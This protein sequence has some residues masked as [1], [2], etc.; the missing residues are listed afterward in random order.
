MD[1]L[2]RHWEKILLTAA[3]L[4]LLT[5]G[6]ILLLK[7]GALSRGLEHDLIPRAGKGAPIPP[8]DSSPYDLAYQRLTQPVLWTNSASDPFQ[9]AAV[10]PPDPDETNRPAAL[11]DCAITLLRVRQEPFTMIF[12][13]YIGDGR[14]FQINM[15]FRPYSFFVE[16]AGDPIR[17]QFNQTGYVVTQ[18][19]KKFVKRQD[20]R[21]GR[22]REVDVSELTV[23]HQGEKPVVLVLG[24]PAV[25]GEPVATVACQCPGRGPLTTT[26]RRGQSF[27]CGFSGYN[28]VDIKPD[29]MVIVDP[30]KPEEKP[31]EIQLRRATPIKEE[32]VPSVW[33]EGFGGPE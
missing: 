2:K 19:T 21:L 15:Q 32:E 17:D 33:P 30:Q 5:A 24:Q 8:L 9:P 27:R 13:A 28:V 1:Q 31:I 14:N 25:H 18:F 3:L 23:Q 20:P 16:K 10:A 12:L 7:I 29:R 26:V 4:A 11:L 22:D 6:V